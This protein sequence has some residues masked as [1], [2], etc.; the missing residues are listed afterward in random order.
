[1]LGVGT[2]MFWKGRLRLLGL[3][4]VAVT[5][6]AEVPRMTAAWDPRIV[7][8]LLGVDFVQLLPWSTVE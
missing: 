2:A 8:T 5:L 1:M 7:L 6:E 3:Q 4:H